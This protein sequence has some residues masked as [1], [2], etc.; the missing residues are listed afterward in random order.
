VGEP[1]DAR[2]YVKGSTYTLTC[3]HCGFKQSFSKGI[4]VAWDMTHVCKRGPELWLV[5]GQHEMKVG[6][7][8]ADRT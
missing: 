6:M 5:I 3:S 1:F 8:D 2:I 7:S 4:P